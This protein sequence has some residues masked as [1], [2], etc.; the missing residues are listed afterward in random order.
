MLQED[1]DEDARYRLANIL[2]NEEVANAFDLTFIDAPPRL[3][4]AAINGFCAS[5][6]LLVPTVYDMMSV[7]AIGTFLSGVQTLKSHLNPAID[8]LGIV[9]TLTSRQ[10]TLSTREQNA[11]KAATQQVSRVWS[12]NHHFFDRHIPRR[13]AIAKTAG[14][15]IAYY[16]DQTVEGWFNDLGEAM[17]QRLGWPPLSSRRPSHA[18]CQLNRKA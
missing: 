5:T 9:G 11:K 4:A 7:E 6:H 17:S 15:D 13:E 1:A 12:A 3:T 10:D 16:C 18:R 8:L 14:G 2:L